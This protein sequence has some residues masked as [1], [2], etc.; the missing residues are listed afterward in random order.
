MKSSGSAKKQA[1]G[2]TR[3]FQGVG[4]LRGYGSEG[5]WIPIE[6]LIYFDSQNKIRNVAYIRRPDGAEIPDGQYEIVDELG[7]HYRRWTK[8]KGN[9]KVKWRHRWSKHQ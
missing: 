2:R 6:F 9:W 3:A 7:E 1:V 4:S 5:D 8:W